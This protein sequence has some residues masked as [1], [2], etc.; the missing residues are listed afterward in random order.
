MNGNFGVSQSMIAAEQLEKIL[1]VLRSQGQVALAASSVKWILEELAR[2][3]GLK[4][5]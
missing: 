5:P 1:E 2:R 4:K 3:W